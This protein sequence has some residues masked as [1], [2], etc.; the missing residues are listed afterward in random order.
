MRIGSSQVDACSGR[1][2]RRARRARSNSSRGAP[3]TGDALALPLSESWLRFAGA[4]VVFALYLATILSVL[5]VTG[6]WRRVF[7]EHF[8]GVAAGA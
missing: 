8:P 7:E 5:K 2:S 3:A 4:V 1:E 6:A